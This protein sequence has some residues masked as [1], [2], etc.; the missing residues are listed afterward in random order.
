MFMH[1]YMDIDEFQY[2]VS[3]GNAASSLIQPFF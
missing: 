3:R 1:L 2:K